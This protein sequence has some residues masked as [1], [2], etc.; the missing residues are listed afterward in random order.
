MGNEETSLELR[1]N[2]ALTNIQATELDIQVTTAKAYP[3]DVARCIK[4]MKSYVEALGPESAEDLFYVLPGRKGK[5]GKTSEPIE[6]PSVRLAEIC[7][8]TWGNLRAQARI[9]G[10]R[11]HNIIAEATVWD[12]EKNYAVSMEK[13]R[14]IFGKYGKYSDDMIAKSALAA[15]SIAFRDTVYRILPRPVVDALVVRAKQLANQSG[16]VAKKRKSLLDYFAKLGVPVE[17]VL[18]F[19]D[20]ATAEEITP[21]QLV[22]MRGYATAIKEGQT[23]AEEVF[24]PKTDAPELPDSEKAAKRI[25]NQIE[26]EAFALTLD[27]VRVRAVVKDKYSVDLDAMDPMQLAVCLKWLRSC[28]PENFPKPAEGNLV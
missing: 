13:A 14:P 11:D 23:T 19:L 27:A 5:D 10:E 2:A 9:V 22:E 15:Q 3:R 28:E 8:S 16:D 20:C 25:I 18:R 26:Q 4:D 12:M 17:T 6:G 7:A 1:G 24:T 21:G